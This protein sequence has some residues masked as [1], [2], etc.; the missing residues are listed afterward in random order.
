[1]NR[2]YKNQKGFTLIELLMAVAVLAVIITPIFGLYSATF[3]NNQ[4]AKD[5]TIA[6][7]LAQAKLEELKSKDYE[8]LTVMIGNDIEETPVEEGSKFNRR[9]EV[10]Q[11]SPGLLE[12][13]VT[14]YWNDGEM[15]LSTLK[16]DIE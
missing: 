15:K 12:I 9:T 6:V 2:L 1:M 5:K 8:E 10:F 14:V 13:R 7:A 16:G 11:K 4:A 3:K